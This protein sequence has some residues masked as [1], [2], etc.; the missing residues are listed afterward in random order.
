MIK[1]ET[2]EPDLSTRNLCIAAVMAAFVCIMT[3]VPRIPIPLGYAHLGDAVIFL[4]AFYS[5]HKESAVAASIGSAFADLIGGFPIWI[6][7][8]IAIKYFMVVIIWK[9]LKSVVTPYHILSWPV[10]AGFFLS[11]FWMVVGYTLSGAILYG[12]L[13][14]GL[15]AAPG[16]ILEGIINIV[17]A[18][19]VGIFLEHARFHI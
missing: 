10:L 18:I 6:I 2:A 13:A 12:G 3:I 1:C 9:I 16:L 17:V 19:A 11:G 5:T 14:V 15:T 8:T 7:P 4:M